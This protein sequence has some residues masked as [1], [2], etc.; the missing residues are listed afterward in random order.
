M[1]GG[2]FD[3]KQYQINDLV[4]EMDNI[5]KKIDINKTTKVEDND[6]EF[7]CDL[8]EYIENIDKFKKKVEYNKKILKEA[9]I[10]TQ[11]ID[12]FLSGDDGEDNFYKRLEEDLKI[13]K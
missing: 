2:M 10:Y 6:D 1:S 9:A 13:I 11:R 3:Y 5:L 4:D 7:E 8:R 12:W